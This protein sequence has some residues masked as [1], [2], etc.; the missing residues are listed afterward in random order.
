MSPSRIDTNQEFAGSRLRMRNIFF[1]GIGQ[2]YLFTLTSS[3]ATHRCSLLEDCQLRA[4]MGDEDSEQARRFPWARI[5][6]E[7]MPVSG[8]FKKALA[9]L[10]DLCRSVAD[11]S[12]RIA[13]E[14]LLLRLQPKTLF[15]LPVH[16]PAAPS[17]N[18]IFVNE[19]F[20]VC[21]WV[22][23]ELLCLSPIEILF[24]LQ[25]DLCFS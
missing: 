17:A 7:E 20:I 19:I 15:Q 16:W 21:P 3:D 2:A 22:P 1:D 24:D 8:R 23:C 14:R 4:V 10:V 13:P 18:L 6:A 25:C 9:S 11:F 12:E 5:L